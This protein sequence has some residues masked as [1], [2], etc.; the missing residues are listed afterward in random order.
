MESK[1]LV[2]RKA[3]PEDKRN[4][5]IFLTDHARDLE[6]KTLRIAHDVL[7]KAQQGV[8][9]TDLKVLKRVLKQMIGNLKKPENDSS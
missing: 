6:N 4:K 2:F 9:E 7:E 3:N 8:S 1:G 5:L